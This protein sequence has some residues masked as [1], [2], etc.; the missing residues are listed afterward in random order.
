[1]KRHF[2]YI[3]AA[4]VIVT[5]GCAKTGNIRGKVTIDGLPMAGV[6]VSDGVNIVLTDSK[7][8]YC[9]DSKKADSVVFITTP[10][11]AVAVSEDGLRPGFWARL[12]KSPDEVERHDFK[13]LTENQ[14]RYSVLFLADL[15]LS[16]DPDKDDLRRFRE[17]VVPFIR[18]KAAE[19]DGPVYMMDL[20]DLSHDIFWYEFDFD[21]DDAYKVVAEQKLPLKMYSVPGNHDH[22]GAIVGDNVDFRSGWLYRRTWGPD[23]YSVNIGNEH[24]VFLDNII[25]VNDEGRGK[26]APGIKGARNYETAFL[27]AQLDWL[28]KDLSYVPDS[29]NVFICTHCPFFGGSLKNGGRDKMP[30]E[31]LAFIDSLCT[32]FR[33]KALNFAG[34]IHKFDFFSRKEYP[35]LFQYGLPC[36]SGVMWET[37]KENLLYCNDGSEAGMMCGR[38]IDNAP[39][40]LHFETYEHGVRNYSIYDLNC[41]GEAYRNSED[42]KLLLKAAP[43]RVDYSA[44]K[45]RNSVL[46]NWWTW[47]PGYYVEMYENGKALKVSTPHTEDPVSVFSYDLPQM[48]HPA[49]HHAHRQKAGCIHTFEAKASRSDSPV[50]V[51]FR[52]EKG[53]ELYRETIARPLPFVF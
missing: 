30:A 46:V 25:Y 44:G 5:G 24:W 43:E 16:N 28:E 15:H 31:Q 52:N 50:E 14:E 22:D 3:L 45:F 19:S 10:S 35:A 9:I 33:Q 11:D 39:F 1:M 41:V 6:Q 4:L 21:V 48:T 49:R 38:G 37:P 2:L 29:C 20:G 32:R 34:H 53:E 17:R 8:R 12:T 27:P 51:V 13:L 42:F 36:A 23:R 18:K 47:M 26:K 40:K 7:G